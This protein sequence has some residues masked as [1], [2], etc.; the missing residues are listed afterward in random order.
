MSS[1]SQHA[2][3]AADRDADGVTS[4]FVRNYVLTGGHTRPRHLLSLETELEPGPGR[5]GPE[6][7]QECGQILALCQQR[8][9][10]IA[11]VAGT[12][13]RPV[14]TVK[15]LV[16]FLLDAR[17]VQLPVTDGYTQ[18]ADDSP[19]GRRPTRQLLEALSAGLKTKWSDADAYP[20]AG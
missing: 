20:R 14:S 7:P 15:V 10:S 16:S 9:L 1:Q 11:E 12:I 3:L 18:A 4:S 5:P 19:L 17:A 8:R 6:L 2:A 13:R